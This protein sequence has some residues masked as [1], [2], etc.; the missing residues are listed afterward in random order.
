MESAQTAK[1]TWWKASRP[2]A[3]DSF[4][5]SVALT[6]DGKRVEAPAGASVLN[7]ASAAGLYIPALC[8]HPDLPPAEQRGSRDGDSGGCNLCMV[9]VMGMT[10]LQKACSL[11]VEAGMTS[12]RPILPASSATIRTSA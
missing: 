8:A 5:P 2:A 10:G 4:G 7:A 11:A 9:E 3:M 12:A 6:I 1:I